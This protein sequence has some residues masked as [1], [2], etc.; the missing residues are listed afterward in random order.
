MTG[1]E[2]PYDSNYFQNYQ[3]LAQ[4]DQG[5]VITS[6]RAALVSRWADMEAMTV[7]D[8]GIG[9]GQFVEAMSMRGWM[10]YGTDVNPV[11]LDWLRSRSWLAPED[12]KADVLTFWDVLEHIPDP[13][14]IFQ[15][16]QPEWIFLS[17][18]IY[19]NE[20]HVFRSKHY[21]PGE[22]C[23]YFTEEGLRRFMH[24]HGYFL[25]ELSATE[26]VHGGREDVWSFAFQKASL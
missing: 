5:R 4:T 8:I 2:I 1:R 11:A 20:Q 15:K 12:L 24:R 19:H 25:I 9:A 23:W 16:H 14:T 10:I 6:N 21:K 3:R 18:P 17:M 22:H 26:I 7:L 13:S